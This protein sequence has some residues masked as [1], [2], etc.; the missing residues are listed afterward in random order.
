M[1]NIVNWAQEDSDEE[2]EQV[3]ND[4]KNPIDKSVVDSNDNDNNNAEDTEL[5]KRENIQNTDKWE[6]GLSVS[7]L[8][9]DATENDIIGFFS[10]NSCVVERVKIMYNNH[11][12]SN[13]HAIIFFKN[14]T[15]FNNALKRAGHKLLGREISIHSN[16]YAKSSKVVDWQRKPNK[17]SRPY[18]HR[19]VIIS[20][21]H[22]TPVLEKSE[23]KPVELKP[24]TK[25]LELLGQPAATSSIF[26]EGKPRDVFIHE[27]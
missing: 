2:C 15:S 5:D 13:G 1:S 8:S 10:D 23:R 22:P 9:Y 6:E 11:G 18:S 17:S 25:P 4:E 7:N 14:I 21:S 20:D 24:R 3:E 27:V 12:K 26:G 16:R 19:E